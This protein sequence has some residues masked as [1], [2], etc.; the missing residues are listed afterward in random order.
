VVIIETR[1]KCL[2]VTVSCRAPHLQQIFQHLAIADDELKFFSA[3]PPAKVSPS[4]FAFKVDG[5]SPSW[6][7]HRLRAGRR[8]LRRMSSVLSMAA[9]R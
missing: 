8:C 6:R 7:A 9:R 5:W 4:T 1:G 2:A 3:L